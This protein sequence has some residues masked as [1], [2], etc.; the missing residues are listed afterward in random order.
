MS[1]SIIANSDLTKIE[2]HPIDLLIQLINFNN[3][4]I[5]WDKCNNDSLYRSQVLG[6]NKRIYEFI[7]SIGEKETVW[8]YSNTGQNDNYHFEAFVQYNLLIVDHL[9][10]VISFLESPIKPDKV[11]HDI[12]RLLY[13][14]DFRLGTTS[15]LNNALIRS[16]DNRI[17]KNIS[18]PSLPD[19]SLLNLTYGNSVR[20][21]EWKK[22]PNFQYFDLNRIL[23]FVDDARS[24]CCFVPIEDIL[25]QE[26][27]IKYRFGRVVSYSIKDILTRTGRI[28]LDFEAQYYWNRNNDKYKIWNV[29]IDL[30]NLQ[31]DSYNLVSEENY[32]L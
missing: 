16:W 29:V 32:P 2:D 8:K 10:R 30:Y 28:F 7:Q 17:P 4:K 19:L 31:L 5:N 21:L 12:H 11:H 15:A 23:L 22:N 9:G 6:A 13:G 1:I 3:S 26:E 24:I 14:R 20:I 18:D 25:A 27:A